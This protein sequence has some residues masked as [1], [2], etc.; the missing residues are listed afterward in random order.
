M[1]RLIKDVYFSADVETDGSVPGP[2]SMLSFSMVLA[3]T[4]DGQRFT[5]PHSYDEYFYAELA[6]IS[7]NF[8]P[9]ALAVN[10]LDRSRLILTGTSPPDAMN[11]AYDWVM[12]TSLGGT[13]IL[14]AYP[15]AFDWT[16]LYWY[17]SVFSAKGSPFGYSNCYDIKTAFAAKGGSQVSLSGRSK[18]PPRLQSKKPHTHNAVD[19]AIEQAEIFANV[20]EWR[21]DRA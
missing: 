21:P 9:E 14:V 17:F 5:R 11:A 6:P 8:Q 20:F 18:M 15:V 13:P 7:T 4:F 2:Y 16:W 10:G 12:R 3:G 1:D 19:D